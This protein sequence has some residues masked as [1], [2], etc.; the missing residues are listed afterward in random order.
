MQ[1]RLGVVLSFFCIGL[2]SWAIVVDPGQKTVD[3]SATTT[4]G[5]LLD[6][7]EKAG[8][9]KATFSCGSIGNLNKKFPNKPNATLHDLGIPPTIK[10]TAVPMKA[11]AAKE[12]STDMQ[13]QVKKD[14]LNAAFADKDD[15]LPLL[16]LLAKQPDKT[17]H[18]ELVASAKTGIPDGQKNAFYL[19]ARKGNVKIFHTL[20]AALT[21]EAFAKIIVSKTDQGQSVLHAAARATK[22]ATEMI[23]L[24]V[25]LAP[26]LVNKTNKAG[27]TP[28]E[29]ALM[30]N[31][32]D[33]GRLAA[34]L[35]LK[36]T[37]AAYTKHPKTI[38]QNC[39][40]VDKGGI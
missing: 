24:V 34:L 30:F 12:N 3:V 26:D 20:Q 18:G 2:N 23:N 40:S 37:D 29:V 5:E 25:S 14:I 9:N 32:K 16:T 27:C 1:I 6:K 36:P 8:F 17:K 39:K 19:A 31:L 21:K 13:D 35:N 11:G 38:G 7:V 33:D 15:P 4:L 10:C 28:F 22:N